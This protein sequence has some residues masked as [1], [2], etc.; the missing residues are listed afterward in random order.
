MLMQ[1]PIP[2]RCV[3]LAYLLIT[4]FPLYDLPK[5]FVRT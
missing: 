2:E 4:H 5:I 3:V 1:T